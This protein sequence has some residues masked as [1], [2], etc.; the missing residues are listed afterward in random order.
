MGSPT[1]S[2]HIDPAIKVER[3]YKS[4]PSSGSDISHHDTDDRRGRQYERERSSTAKG[5]DDSGQ[6]RPDTSAGRSSKPRK[7]KRSRKGLEKNFACS[8]PDCGKTYSRAEHLYRH[9]LNRA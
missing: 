4:P 2:A 1:D 6:E 9:Q 8:H 3:P 5:E 7:R